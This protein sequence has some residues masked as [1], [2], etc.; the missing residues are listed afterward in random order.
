MNIQFLFFNNVGRLRSGWRLLIFT[1]LFFLTLSFAAIAVASVVFTFFGPRAHA[2]W[3]GIW[4]HVAQQSLVLFL[5]VGIGWL[6]ARSLEG[7]PFRAMGW[8]PHEGWFRDLLI[9]SCAGLLSLSIA[10][11]I[12]SLGGGL[13]FGLN[14]APA[15]AVIKTVVGSLL[16]FLLFGASEEALF[17][18]YPLQTMT[19]ARLAWVSIVLT[20]ALFG[21]AHLNNPNVIPGFT[22]I[23]TA[24]AGVWL[25]LA[26]L[27]TRSLWLPLGL[28]WSW[29]W[30]MGAVFGLP[31]SGI[32]KITPA[33]LFKAFET[34]P[35]WL[36]GGNYGIEGGAACTVALII[37]TAWLWKTKMLKASPEM[38][39]LTD[40]EHAGGGGLRVLPRRLTAEPVDSA[41]QTRLSSD[42]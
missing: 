31:V 7:L 5:A 30:M 2:F 8:S 4:G 14:A 35:H 18:G 37:S 33:P 17:R 23:N 9:G 38:L 41:E 12:A 21:Q 34:G 28:H 13:G 19:R 16:A 27:R 25:A 11:G 1:V 29:N 6:C 39:E 22:F 24:L 10:V 20:A 32:S 40:H 3:T 15:T 42:K 26:Y 36:T